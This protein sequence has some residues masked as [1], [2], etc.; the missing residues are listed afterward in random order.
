MLHACMYWGHVMLTHV[1]GALIQFDVLLLLHVSLTL[2]H[3]SL[4][5]YHV[6]PVGKRGL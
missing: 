6:S 5:L 1:D 2:Y 3:V 4:T